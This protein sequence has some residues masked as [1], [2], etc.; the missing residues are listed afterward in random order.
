LE[1]RVTPTILFNPVFGAESPTSNAPFTILNDP[2]VYVIMWGSGWGTGPGQADPTPYLTEAQSILSGPYLSG[3]SEY[4]S[5]GKATFAGAFVVAPS[6]ASVSNFVSVAGPDVSAGFDPGNLTGNNLS[7]AA[8]LLTSLLFFPGGVPN[9]NNSIYAIIPSPSQNTDAGGYNTTA[10]V[11]GGFAET[12]NVMSMG[13]N[14][15]LANFGGD[16]SHEMAEKMSDPNGDSSGV[17]VAAPTQ[18]YPS[19]LT[20]NPQIGDNEA[21]PAFQAHYAYSLKGA[22]VQPYWSENDGAFIVPDD[23]SLQFTLTASWTVS[24]GIATINTSSGS[25]LYNLTINP[26]Q[27]GTTVDNTLDIT[28]ASG[29]VQV[30]LDH[31]TAT[32]SGMVI[33]SITVDMGPQSQFGAG[34]DVN[35]DALPANTPLTI[36]LGGGNNSIFLSPTAENLNTVQSGVIIN[37]GPVAGPGNGI[38]VGTAAVFVDDQNNPAPNT[39]TV[40]PTSIAAQTPGIVSYAFMNFVTLSGGSS[41]KDQY[42]INGVQTQLPI[43][44]SIPLTTVNTLGGTVDV[45]N[46][47]LAQAASALVLVDNGPTTVNVRNLAAN[48]SLGIESFSSAGDLISIGAGN[49]ANV[50]GTVTIGTTPQNADSDQLVINDSGDAAKQSFTIAKANNESVLSIGNISYGVNTLSSL[51]LIGG[52]GGDTWDVQ[53]TEAPFFVFP[54]KFP[55]Q[56][57][58]TIDSNGPD[59]I[60]VGDGTGVQDINGPLVIESN[61]ADSD[62]LNLNDQA[63]GRARTVTVTN[64]TVSGL[65]PA[66]ITYGPT[67]PPLNIT[68][69]PNEFFVGA[70]NINSGKGGDTFNVQSTQTDDLVFLSPRHLFDF[71]TTTTITSGGADTVTVGDAN[72]VQDIKGPLVVNNNGAADADTLILNDRGDGTAH[73]VTVTGSSVTGLAPAV[74]SYGVFALD[75]LEINGGTG[76]DTFNVQSTPLPFTLPNPINPSILLP[77]AFTTTTITSD[78]ADT[79]NVGDGNGVQDIQ[80]PLTLASSGAVPVAVTLDDQADG[81][82]QTVTMTTGAVSGLA[83]FDIDFGALALKSLGI[84]GGTGANTWNVQSTAAPTTLTA[85]GPDTLVV[86]DGKGVQDINGTL[87]LATGTTLLEKI[88]L[89]VNDH[90]DGKARQVTVSSGSVHGLAPADIVF[91]SEG[92]E[93]ALFQVN[94]EG[95]SGGTAFTVPSTPSLATVNLS[96][97]GTGNSVTGPDSGASWQL[98]PTGDFF[99]QGI[100]FPDVFFSGMQSLIGGAGA[101]TFQFIQGTTF[102]GTVDGGPGSDALDF[103]Q[104]GSPVTVAIIGPG[105]IDGQKGTATPIINA[106][107]FNNINSILGA[108]AT[109]TIPTATQLSLPS[110]TVVFGQ[111][112]NLGVS[113]K[114]LK[115]SIAF[116]AGTVVLTE[117]A[118]QIASAVLDIKGAATLSAKLT[119]SGTL[120]A[121]YEGNG[122]F[123]ASS[124]TLKVTVNKDS[125]TVVAAAAPNLTLVGKTVTLTATV[126]AKAPG[127]G[128]PTG[129]VTFKA[130]STVLGTVALNGSGVASLATT[131]I[132][133]GTITITMSYGGDANFLS[134]TGSISQVVVSK[135][136]ATQ[137]KLQASPTASVVGQPVTLTATI[138]SLTSPKFQPT[139]LPAE[140]VSFFDGTTKL[141]SAPLSNTGVAKL[142]VAPFF[143]AGTHSITARYAGA[144][145]FQSSTSIALTLKVTPAA[146][147]VA[148]SSSLNPAPNTNAVTFTATVTAKAP[149]AGTP[150]G[151]VTFIDGAIDLGTVSLN[152]IGAAQ[153][154]VATLKAGSHAIFAIYGGSSSYLSSESGALT[155]QIFSKQTP[156]ASVNP[157][158]ITFG[159]ALNNGQLSGTATVSGQSVQGTFTY[160][161][162]AGTL[163]KAS[164]QPQIIAVTFTPTDPT[165]FTVATTTVQVTVNQ[166]TPQ[167]AVGPVNLIGGTPL[168]NSQLQNGTATATVNGQAGPV[169]GSFAYTNAA[170][171]TLRPGQGQTEAVTFTPFDNVDFTTVKTNVV[172]NVGVVQPVVSVNPV[173]LTY[174][175]A[176]DDSQLTGT[177]TFNGQSVQGTL[178]YVTGPGSVLNASAQAQTI[179]VTFTPSDTTD[180]TTVETTVQVTVNQAAPQ[181][182]VGPVSL[183]DGTPLDNSQLQ[184]GTATA[185]V[186]GQAGPVAGTF[187]YTNAA[188]ITLSPGQGQSEAVTFTPVDQVDFS[189]VHTNVIVNVDVAQPAVSVNAVS[190]V[191]GTALDNSQLTGTST[192]NSQSVQGTFGYTSDAGAVPNASPQ[193]QTFAVTFTPNDTTDFAVVSTTV[194]V[195]VVRQPA[196]VFTNIVNITFG[197]ALD[198]SQLSGT[199]TATVNGQSITVPGS[200]RYVGNV[201][202]TILQAGPDQFE[203]ASFTPNDQ[204]FDGAFALVFINVAQAQPQVSVNPVTITFGTGLD[205]SQL[206]GTATFNGQAVQGTF[207][208]TSAAGTMLNGSAQAQTIAVTFT[209]NDTT[210]FAV[211]STTV[212]IAVN[213]ATPTISLT[214]FNNPAIVNQNIFFSVLVQAPG[215]GLIPQGSV[216]F[217]DGT[218]ALATVSV[219][220]F[221]QATLTTNTLPIGTHFITAVYADTVDGNFGTVTSAVLSQIV[222]QGR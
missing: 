193:A 147:S 121:T 217:F 83:P 170:G 118:K 151:T 125:T 47:G 86:G 142:A 208:Y 8:S 181:V 171:T 33:T 112:I 177:A 89:T 64:T 55:L 91:S 172:V 140:L 28:T 116:P 103:T 154:V 72:G 98:T 58:T 15:N 190:L 197:T 123:S 153:L 119:T 104:F 129:K 53:S 134:S 29:A 61:V 82:G 218:Q 163:L 4:G 152:T 93:V 126:G 146:T 80:G 9:T 5:D 185:T 52:T 155:E 85:N 145:V 67:S 189:L 51:L 180:F 22:I 87:T 43:L 76:G 96:A 27:P 206:S 39:Y 120:T 124:A 19:N 167:V 68:P 109:S 70:L 38:E 158:T 90:G 122:T 97:Q 174:G 132:P 2:S 56:T 184:N 16:F 101:D 7:Q 34:D 84:T 110:T 162:A 127:S 205:N 17:T 21:A 48:S 60:N 160:T 157:V 139:T 11:S 115:A 211:V 168:N 161:S 219:N 105:T 130:G 102:A 49:L 194:E 41:P 18:N 81:T 69:P 133:A 200:F 36:N 220:A 24:N 203:T 65:A 135:T 66:D 183:A 201:D 207:S 186:N 13:A 32:F 192:F 14:G 179:A 73:T 57:T 100:V 40:T 106:G 198:N 107:T 77:I 26:D 23:N 6:P 165:H 187:A 216:T 71:T 195:T 12:V 212:Q 196:I 191:F 175:T 141:G 50:A 148:L 169:A 137:T 156:T 3:L 222:T 88:K 108:A 79:I 210:D 37:P 164:A 111:V 99:N 45:N 59:L 63:D 30:T 202:G 136:V 114:A 35:V 173:S 144:Q 128:T 214:S 75:N 10:V 166:A 92:A 182:V 42:E 62:T 178:R 31:Q 78:G 150:H 143:V 188:G 138:I 95:G 94:V 199:A 159:T 20:N 113:V 44:T 215:A 213:P 176:L 25:I 149:G 117:G 54:N 209:P 204:N 1:D 46:V 131:K 74:V 221:G